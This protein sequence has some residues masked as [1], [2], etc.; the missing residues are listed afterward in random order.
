MK[1]TVIGLM[2]IMT[3]GTFKPIGALIATQEV[4]TVEDVKHFLN[5][6]ANRF[7]RSWGSR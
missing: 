3:A 5:Y 6:V 7:L 4:E 2:K 1:N